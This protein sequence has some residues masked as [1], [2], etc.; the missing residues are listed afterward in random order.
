VNNPRTVSDTKRSFYAV[1]TRPINSIYR[2]VVEE[3]LVE[4]HLLRVNADF[5]YDPV[6][7]LGILTAF[8]RFMQGYQPE[9]DKASIF[10]ALC[11]SEEYDP[12]KLKQDA[13]SLRE[14][15]VGKSAE[16]LVSWLTQAATMGGDNLQN[17]L[18]AIATN[19]KFKYSRLFAIGMFTLLEAIEPEI[20]KDETRLNELLQQ[21]CSPMNLPEAKLQKDLEQY[22]SNLE[23]MT[24]ARKTLEEI[25]AADRK[26]RLEQANAAQ[27][28]SPAEPPSPSEASS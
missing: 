23:K 3:L 11:L 22:R 17:Q 4:I 6:F 27:N 15:A 7:A 25:I 9:P 19:P 28:T 21:V 14:A 13:T 8:E 16:Q 20:G 10:N 26:K 1:H 18:R 24:Q 5:V 2:R 12:S